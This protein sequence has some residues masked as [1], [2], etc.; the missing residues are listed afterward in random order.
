[1]LKNLLAEIQNYSGTGLSTETGTVDI[2]V[3][4]FLNR[5]NKARNDLQKKSKKKMLKSILL[6]HLQWKQKLDKS[7]IALRHSNNNKGSKHQN[8]FQKNTIIL[9]YS[10]IIS[11]NHTKSD[12]IFR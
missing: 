12:Q 4:I 11:D 1:M 2:S 9:Y 10:P 5:S 8:I 7:E 6:E 3:T